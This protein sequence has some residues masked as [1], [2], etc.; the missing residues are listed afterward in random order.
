MG[1]KVGPHAVIVMRQEEHMGA[2][3]KVSDGGFVTQLIHIVGRSI[4]ELEKALG[5]GTG[6]LAGGYTLLLL[7]DEVRH[8][9]FLMAGT[10]VFPDGIPEGETKRTDQLI[11]ESLSRHPADAKRYEGLKK[12]QA[13]GIF[14]RS[15]PRRIVKV[16]AI[17]PGNHYPKGEHVPQWILTAAKSFVV[18]PTV[19]GAMRVYRRSDDSIY[20]AETLAAYA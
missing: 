9:E 15:G 10:T 12:S 7:D 4:P 13:S 2:I 6:H 16:K 19:H 8:D 3:A 18:G 11:K 1:W 20:A 17:S 5:F 14:L